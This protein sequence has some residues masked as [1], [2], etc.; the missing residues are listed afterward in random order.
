MAENEP[1]KPE[2]D[3]ENS[4]AKD[5]G[6]FKSAVISASFIEKTVLLLLTAV[7]SG[8]LIPYVSNKIQTA[9]A[10]TEVVLQSEAKLL[11]D[12]TNTM[13]TYQF[14]VGDVSLY[15]RDSSAAND[16]MQAA[17]FEHYSNRVVDLFSQWGVEIAKSKSLASPEVSE[18]LDKFMQNVLEDQD[19]RLVTL[20]ANNGSIAEWHE[21][22]DM[23][24]K[25]YE[26]AKALIGELA[27]D[28]KITKANI[29]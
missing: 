3:I 11:D 19:S 16:K 27:I 6:I 15:K 23:N 10:H 29:K 18:K 5:P 22:D 20:Y 24:G 12:I 26:K 2:V 8:L 1:Q 17:A 7:I 25:M 14:L 13:I 4:P 21:L 9:N 28:F